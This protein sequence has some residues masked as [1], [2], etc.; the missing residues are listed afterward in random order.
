MPIADQVVLSLFPGIG[1][2]DTAFEL[3]GFCVV[4]GPDPLWGGDVA[5]FHIPPGRFDGIIGGP[6]CQTFSVLSFMVRQNGR[7]PKFGN[8]IPEFERVVIEGQPSWFIMENVP[9][10]PLPDIPG[11]L[12]DNVIVNNRRFGDVLGF[13]ARQHRTRRFSFG[14][15]D[16][17]RLPLDLA[18]LARGA[19]AH[20][21][22]GGQGSGLLRR[23]AYS[24]EEACELQGL[25]RD[26]CRD[27]P[28]TR[29]GKFRAIGNAV[30]I[31][32]GRAIARGVRRAMCL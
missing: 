4:R 6:P 10:A 32:M 16:G 9:Q 13:G 19:A 26:F 14:T 8:M 5:R 12:L 17:A 25:P 24:I 18:L 20:A 31:P 23:H 22:L 21:V 30:P 27:M 11:Y 2:L 7:Q 3:E 28:F 1:L 29:A 15:R